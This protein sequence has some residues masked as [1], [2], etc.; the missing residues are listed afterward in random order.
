MLESKVHILDPSS[1]STTPKTHYIYLLEKLFVILKPSSKS[2]N[3]KYNLVASVPVWKGTLNIIHDVNEM[4]SFQVIFLPSEQSNKLKTLLIFVSK[5]EIKKQWVETVRKQLEKNVRLTLPSLPANI[6]K[7]LS[8]IDSNQSKK[9]WKKLVPK[10]AKTKGKSEN[11]LPPYTSSN[12]LL[13]TS[14]G[15]TLISSTL[16][17][18]E[19][20]II[21]E[22]KRK[23]GEL[24]KMKYQE[25]ERNEESGDSPIFNEYPS[26][27]V[28][29]Q[30]YNTTYFDNLPMMYD[31]SNRISTS[32]SS[33]CSS[34][35]SKMTTICTKYNSIER[36]TYSY[37]NTS[38]YSEGTAYSGVNNSMNI[39]FNNL[40]M[41]KM[42]STEEEESN[43][44]FDMMMG[45]DSS[46]EEEEEEEEE[47]EQEGEGENK[48]NYVKE[49]TNVNLEP[50]NSESMVP[51]SCKEDTIELE[52]S[53]NICMNDI[54]V[55]KTMNYNKNSFLDDCINNN[56]DVTEQNLSYNDHYYN[57]NDQ[58]P[59]LLIHP[60]IEASSS[61]SEAN[62]SFMS[63]SDLDLEKSS[64]R[65]KKKDS[66]ETFISDDTKSFD[67]N[68]IRQLKTTTWYSGDSKSE[69]EE[70]KRSVKNKDASLFNGSKENIHKDNGANVLLDFD[71]IHKETG[72]NILLE[73]EE[74]E[75]RN[76]IRKREISEVSS[77][78]SLKSVQMITKQMLSIHEPDEYH[79]YS[80]LN[81]TPPLIHYSP[82]YHVE[83]DEESETLKEDLN[84][85]SEK[86]K[87]GSKSGLVVPTIHNI[88]KNKNI[89]KE[90]LSTLLSDEDQFK[91]MLPPLVPI[92]NPIEE[93]EK[94]ELVLEEPELSSSSELKQEV[95]A[96]NEKDILPSSESNQEVVALNATESDLLSLS[97]PKQEVEALT[98]SNLL[99]SK[100]EQN[101]KS[102]I[103]EQS[104]D[105]SSLSVPIEDKDS[106]S[107]T[108]D[109]NKSN[110]ESI[111]NNIIKEK[112]A[113][114]IKEKCGD[115]SNKDLTIKIHINEE[116][117]SNDINIEIKINNRTNED[118][119]PAVTVES[120]SISSVATSATTTTMATANEEESSVKTTEFSSQTPI[121]NYQGSKSCG[122][123]DDKEKISQYSDINDQENSHPLHSRQSSFSPTTITTI[124]TEATDA[125]LSVI[126][127]EEEKYHL[128]TVDPCESKCCSSPA[129]TGYADI[130]DTSLETIIQPKQF[131]NHDSSNEG[132]GVE[133]G[134]PEEQHQLLNM[135]KFNK[136]PF[137]Y[138]FSPLNS[139]SSLPSDF[140]FSVQNEDRVFG[141]GLLEKQ[142]KFFLNRNHLHILENNAM[143]RYSDSFI[144]Y[145]NVDFNKKEGEDLMMPHLEE[146]EPITLEE[147]LIP[148]TTNTTN[149][150][151]NSNT[152]INDIIN[153]NK[154]NSSLFLKQKRLPKTFL[155]NSRSQAN[156]STTL[157]SLS[158]TYVNFSQDIHPSPNKS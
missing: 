119:I 8:A 37:D 133:E 102:I 128:P 74:L 99:L 9:K 107:K 83:E 77:I 90:D 66:Y 15:G 68:S 112:I 81:L 88:Y 55:N 35:S 63:T 2:D 153:K 65:L 17:N 36:N 147:K 140:P 109:N 56:I 33:T 136:N 143:N 104:I 60:T 148:N 93:N 47:K 39:N 96:L 48:E 67:T 116:N 38:S 70:L 150:T 157:R 154:E 80:K 30:S 129:L 12:L 57:S 144:H 106:L 73:L 34:S 32:S 158:D 14:E 95:V 5:P 105:S 53:E 78:A 24:L 131:I 135:K 123:A 122:F 97:E 7:D 22:E 108:G 89:V 110:S 126:S 42:Y 41:T 137:F 91:H 101:I 138:N 127:N 6:E 124:A 84:Q 113:Q 121:E 28:A 58:D 51:E 31:T 114:E 103:K 61:V 142:F 79:S 76:Y 49:S 59:V 145:Q 151:I 50:I 132:K 111:L 29:A 4:N 152:T 13:K 64:L 141:Y 117:N 23:Q 125:T 27:S 18:L 19:H 146:K 20:R 120:E 155:S 85:N 87:L 118:K 1:S 115:I 72:V 52:K 54:S 156:L 26:S 75:K 43:E 130:N 139:Y 11:T 134:K 3:V 92:G 21:T 40:Q 62:N 71:D 69:T 46:D 86:K 94:E 44:E 149:T 45:N 10:F 82:H 98:E 100:P 16:S 25:M